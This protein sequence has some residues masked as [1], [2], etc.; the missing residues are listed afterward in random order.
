MRITLCGSNT[1]P[2]S[3]RMGRDGGN[4]T[5][6]G[7]ELVAMARRPSRTRLTESA[8]TLMQLNPPA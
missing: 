2:A 7:R 5:T 4:V 6:S 1:L 3:G 8:R